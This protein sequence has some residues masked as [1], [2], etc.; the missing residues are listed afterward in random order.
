[1][2]VTNCIHLTCCDAL[3]LGTIHIIMF[4]YTGKLINIK[5]F[6]LMLGLRSTKIWTV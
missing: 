6:L 1:M 4:M 3:V 2:C 5:C